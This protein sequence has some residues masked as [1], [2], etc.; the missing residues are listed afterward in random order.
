MAGITLTFGTFREN[1]P[2]LLDLD[3]KPA[4][5]RKPFCDVLDFR[6]GLS[7]PSRGVPGRSVLADGVDC[8]AQAKLILAQLVYRRKNLIAV[9]LNVYVGPYFADL[10]ARI[11]Q[12]RVSGREFRHSKVHGGVIFF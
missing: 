12:E 8:L 6:Y 11:N 5:T 10:T 3:F 7:G 4:A 9:L 2:R 1:R